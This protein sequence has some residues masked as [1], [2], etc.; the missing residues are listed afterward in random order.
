MER[1]LTTEQ[2]KIAKGSIVRYNLLSRPNYAPYCGDIDCKHGLPRAP[3]STEL[4][5]FKCSCGW[6]SSF[7]PEFIAEYKKVWE[8]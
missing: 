7:P 4:N 1:T 5:Q 8:L 2:R 3:F 6:V